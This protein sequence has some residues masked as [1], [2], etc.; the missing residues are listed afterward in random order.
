[1]APG[2]RPATDHRI[3][4]RSRGNLAYTYR[5]AGRPEEALGLAEHAAADYQ[6]LLGPDAP[7]TLAARSSLAAAYQAAG[8]L[9]SAIALHERAVADFERILGADHPAPS[10]PA[11]ISA[12]PARR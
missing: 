1:V 12:T 11:V 10:Q 5:I 2:T 8:Q 7:D 3:T 9:A 4:L 6:R